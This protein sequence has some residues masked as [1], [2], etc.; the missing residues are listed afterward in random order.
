MGSCR[1]YLSLAEVF[2]SGGIDLH[3]KNDGTWVVLTSFEARWKSKHVV[4]PKGF[5][6][7]L[8]SIP[9]IFRTLIPQ[10]GYHLQ[11][12]IVHDLCYAGI[13]LTRKESDDMFLDGMKQQGV[14]FARRWA[15]YFAV[16]AGGWAF[17]KG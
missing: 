10:V 16:R 8:A 6:T 2:Y 12:A 1:G 5:V 14:W 13:G 15:I 4:V 7:D 9:R 17:F 3:W 11:P